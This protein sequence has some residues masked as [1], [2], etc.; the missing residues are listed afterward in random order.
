MNPGSTSAELDVAAGIRA[1]LEPQSI[2]VVG[3]SPNSSVAM[4]NLLN[5]KVLGYSGEVVGVHPKHKEVAGVRCVPDLSEIGFVPDVVTVAVGRNQSVGVIEAAAEMGVSAAVMFGIGFAEADDEGKQLQEHVVRVA[6]EA[7]MLLLGPNCQGMINFNTGVAHYIEEVKP[8]AAGRIGLVAQ[9][10]SIATALINNRRGTRWRYAFSTGNEAMLDAAALLDYMVDDPDC[11]AAC[12]FLEAIRDS[13]RFF[14]ACDRALANNKPVVVLKTGKTESSMRA[15]EAHSGALAV[16]DRLIDARFKRHGVI[17]VGTMEELL[18]TANALAGG[19]RSARGKLATVTAS[20][21]QIQMVLDTS[22]E[23]GL[24]HA[25]LGEATLKTIGDILPDFLAAG[26]P[27]DYF[28]VA[29]EDDAYPKLIDALL[30]DD[31]VDIVMAVVD[32]TD[33]PTG[34]GRFDLR[35]NTALATEPPGGK[36]LAVLESVGGVSPSDRVEEAIAA[37]APLVSGFETGLRAISNVVTYSRWLERVRRKRDSQ[38]KPDQAPDLTPGMTI[39]GLAAMELL[40]QAG[41]PTVETRVVAGADEAVGVAAEL[42]FPVVAKFADEKIAHKTEAGGVVTGVEDEEM[43]RKVC[44]DFAEAGQTEV[45]LQPQLTGIELL[46]GVTR[47][48]TLGAFL[49]VGLGGIWTEILDQVVVVPAGLAEGE[50]ADVLRR[51]KGSELLF[52]ARNTSGVDV[53]QLAQIVERLDD[54]AIGW[55]DSISAID[56]NPVIASPKGVTA[57]DAVIITKHA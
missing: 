13:D 53:E 11:D 32:Q 56:L 52:G 37:G 19:R 44:A 18:E 30:K 7:G 26:N 29:D 42:G 50:A 31:E 46:L 48:E 27:L 51:I 16:P 36:F 43:L 14:A 15:A 39:S 4:A 24:E 55:G 38:A 41:L 9:S 12:L 28:G 8:Y 47:H 6:S 33:Y 57:V 21:G 10:G 40:G 34:E 22:S 35:L 45:L 49:I 20:G 1:L 5:P 25:T 54:I 17:R 23:V 2:A 3:A